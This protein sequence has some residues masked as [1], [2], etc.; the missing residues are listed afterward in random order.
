ML[1]NDFIDIFQLIAERKIAEAIRR[2]EFDD[3]PGQGKPLCLSDDPL[4]PP[5]QRLAH[6]ILKNAGIA[7]IEI[8]LRRELDQLKREYAR[9]KSPEERRT[10]MREIRLM[11]L[12]INL[13][14]RTSVQ[15]EVT[16]AIAATD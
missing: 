9:A 16:E 4:E 10:L 14:H 8:A 11:V 13:M 2:G 3:L 1:P 6:K 12:R 7:P 15:A 5:H